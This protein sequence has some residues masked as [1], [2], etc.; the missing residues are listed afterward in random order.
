MV[1]LLKAAVPFMAVVMMAEPI[2]GATVVKT[3]VGN[4]E[5]TK[6][7]Y[8]EELDQTGY[9]TQVKEEGSVK[10]TKKTKKINGK[11]YVFKFKRTE[12][13]YLKDEFMSCAYDGEKNEST[14]NRDYSDMRI[15]T[16]TVSAPKIKGYEY[17]KSTSKRGK[18][19]IVAY[20]DV[21]RLKENQKSVSGVKETVTA[22]PVGVTSVKKKNGYLYVTA[23][24]N[25]SSVRKITETRKAVHI[26]TEK[27]VRPYYTVLKYRK[28]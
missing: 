20:H 26:T 22:K 2:Y 17:E 28:L 10:Y 6:E 8:S 7:V 23:R 19:T 9:A 16:Y 24:V 12:K 18:Q 15:V 21:A 14:V 5:S 4:I 11:T 25:V 27:A 13:K 1:V 3:E